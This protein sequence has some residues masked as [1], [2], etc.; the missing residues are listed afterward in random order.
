MAEGKTALTID[1]RDLY[2]V[3]FKESHE[4]S[5]RARDDVSMAE[6]IRRVIRERLDKEGK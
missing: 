1:L 5:L 2:D 4:E 6:W 3:V